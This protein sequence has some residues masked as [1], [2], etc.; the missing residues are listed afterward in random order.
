MNSHINSDFSDLLNKP[1]FIFL[2]T[3][4]SQLSLAEAK[5]AAS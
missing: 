3:I 1:E 5:Q 2:S 4:F